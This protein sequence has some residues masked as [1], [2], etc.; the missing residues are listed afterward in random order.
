MSNVVHFSIYADDII[1][2]KTF[3]E[4]VF[5]WQIKELQKNDLFLI[6]PSNENDSDSKIT[7]ST[8]ET[9]FGIGLIQKRPSENLFSAMINVSDIEETR[10][11]I[12]K[13]G[14][15]LLTPIIPIQGVGFFSTFQD[16]EGNVFNVIKEDPYANVLL[17]EDYS[18][19][20]EG[21]KTL[22]EQLGYPKDSILV[23]V[24][25]DD[26]GMHP[27]Q[28]DGALE[29]I[30]YGLCK[31]GSIMVPCPDTE[32]VLKIWKNNPDLD[33][34]I[35][36]TLNSEWGNNY[37]WTPILSK[38]EVPS[39]YNPEGYMWQFGHELQE[40]LNV[41]EAIKELEAQI[42][43]V[44]KAGL[45]PTHLDSHMGCYF[46]HPDLGK[47]VEEIAKRYKLPM[48]PYFME[49]ARSE[50][51]V[52]PNT[53]WQFSNIIGEAWNSN[54]RKEKYH[55]WLKNLKPGVHEVVTHISLMSD[56]LEK[57]LEPAPGQSQ[58]RLNDYYVWTSSETKNLAEKLDIKFIGYKELHK[59]QNK[60][61]Q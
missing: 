60:L 6:F 57:I 32:R 10:K 1:R 30:K 26:I 24:H 11:M 13:N 12:E 9:S 14:G 20:E 18:D 38:E 39:L 54:L 28:S 23:I 52:Y 27:K 50:G 36:L 56:E 3:Y 35:H 58:A 48:I 51:F 4:N 37:R 5:G 49:T 31:T 34:G 47:G 33:L 21:K 16:T 15:K 61:W 40:H 19:K 22:V 2:A 25:A 43:I 59:L 53:F 55:N 44:L 17:W 46:V 42:Q 45:K 41:D 8:L 7:S 29:A